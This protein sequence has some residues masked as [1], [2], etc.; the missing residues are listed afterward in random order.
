[1]RLWSIHPAYLDAK[2]LVALWREGLLAQRVLRGGTKGYTAHPQLV[3]FTRTGNAVGAI[4]SYLRAVAEEGHRRGYRFDRT[5]IA[6]RRIQSQIKV[7][8]GQ[9]HYEFEHLLNKLSVRD[10]GRFERLK[11][12]KRIRPHP[13]FM[14][15]GGDIEAWERT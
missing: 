4:A 10:H 6:N 15:V 12:V 14:R 7:T 13:L 8:G 2:G 11:A 3:R 9:I 5:K 1:M